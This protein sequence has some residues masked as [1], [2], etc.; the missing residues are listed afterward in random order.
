M[1]SFFFRL[2]MEIDWHACTMQKKNKKQNVFRQNNCMLNF[3][4]ICS[5]RVEYISKVFLFGES[6]I[7]LEAL[8]L[9]C[10]CSITSASVDSKPKDRLLP[11]NL[12][13]THLHIFHSPGKVSTHALVLVS[14]LL[15][16][17]PLTVKW[18]N[19]LWFAIWDDFACVS[20]L[21][22]RHGNSLKMKRRVLH[23]ITHLKGEIQCEWIHSRCLRSL[24]SGRKQKKATT[25]YNVDRIAN[26]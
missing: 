17:L 25:Q 4:L 2:I 13:F 10:H 1:L 26:C 7:K 22:H 20:A 8:G 5:H 18:L 16:S 21:R 15:C 3:T 11:H 9:S 12:I 19:C 24:S 23:H 6:L 14:P